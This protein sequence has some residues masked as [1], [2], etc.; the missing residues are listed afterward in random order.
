LLLWTFTGLSPRAAIIKAINVTLRINRHMKKYATNKKREISEFLVCESLTFGIQSSLSLLK[1]LPIDFDHSLLFFI[2]L[3]W[4][5]FL[6]LDEVLFSASSSRLYPEHF[7]GWGLYSGIAY[8]FYISSIMLIQDRQ[9]LVVFMI[10]L[11]S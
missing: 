10:S 7:V 6:R 4:Y 3:I 2:S 11:Y 8:L 9:T 1:F 5:I